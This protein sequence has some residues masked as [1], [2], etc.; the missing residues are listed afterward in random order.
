VRPAKWLDLSQK[1]SV[2]IEYTDFVYKDDE[3]YLNR[4]TSM[5]TEAKLKVLR[6]MLF[7]FRHIYLMKDGGSYLLRD[8]RRKYNRSGENFEHGL[9]LSAHYRPRIDLSLLAEVDFRMQ[10]SNRLGFVGGDK[11]VVSSNVY[12]SGGMKLGIKREREFWE[13]GRMDFDISYVRR[14]GPYI[15]PERRE[16]WE[17]DSS[18]AFNF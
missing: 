18:I 13:N 14:F 6:P 11:V 4:T 8:G 12:E 10:E 5:I 16:Y 7:N 1:Y 2:K 3:N 17:I 15:S 9:F